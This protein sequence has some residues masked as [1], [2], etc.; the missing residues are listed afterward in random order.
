[1]A[2]VA[3]GLSSP[4]RQGPAHGGAAPKRIRR[5]RSRFWSRRAP[6]KTTRRRPSRNRRAHRP[7]RRPERLR[8]DRTGRAGTSQRRRRCRTCCDARCHAVPAPAAPTD[9]RPTPAPLTWVTAEVAPPAPA[10]VVSAPRPRTSAESG[11][12]G[13]TD[14]RTDGAAARCGQH[15]TVG[16]THGVRTLRGL[17]RSA[18]SA[19]AEPAAP[20]ARHPSRPPPRSRALRQASRS[21]MRPLTTRL[22]P[23]QL[24]LTCSAAVRDFEPPAAHEGG[25]SALVPTTSSPETAFEAAPPRRCPR[26]FPRRVPLPAASR[27]RRPSPRT[28][29]PLAATRPRQSPAPRR[30]SAHTPATTERRRPGQCRLAGRPPRAPR[31]SSDKGGPPPLSSRALQANQLRS[32]SRSDGRPP[33]RLVLIQHKLSRLLRPAQQGDRSRRGSGEQAPSIAHERRCDPSSRQ[34][35]RLCRLPRRLN[36]P[37]SRRLRQQATESQSLAAPRAERRDTR[38]RSPPRRRSR[39]SGASRAS[40]AQ[41]PAVDVGEPGPTP[42]GLHSRDE[43]APVG[44]TSPAVEAPAIKRRASRANAAATPA[45]AKTPDVSAARPAQRAAAPAAA[46]PKARARPAPAAG[47]RSH[48][49]TARGRETTRPAAEISAIKRGASRTSAAREPVAKPVAV[50]GEAAAGAVERHSIDEPA[51]IGTTE[52]APAL[53]PPALTPVRADQQGDCSRRET[54]PIMRRASRAPA[55]RVPASA[56]GE[57]LPDAVDAPAIER[58]ASAHERRCDPSGCDDS[59]RLRHPASS[60]CRCTSSRAARSQNPPRPSCSRPQRQDCDNRDSGSR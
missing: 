40:A 30:A 11:S 17:P 6:R 24:T 55:A 20:F 35:A 14:G 44:K 32:A 10:G 58:R 1:M 28:L 47:A 43:P 18:C 15:R 3:T 9:E 36:V 12:G 45:A 50:V 42:L 39:D 51:P 48:E 53:D 31:R 27:H 52:P 54:P 21:R 34:D 29:P 4:P 7:H 33:R 13:G 59:G 60:T 19:L 56:D 46:P 23:P 25:E 22:L 26:T 41:M 16:P 8:L 2:G 37:L 5:R 49:T 57:T 38:R